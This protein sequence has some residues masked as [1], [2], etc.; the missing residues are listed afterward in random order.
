[1]SAPII[2]T[3]PNSYLAVDD[4]E[5]KVVIDVGPNPPSRKRRLDHLTWEE[6]MQRKKLK[7]RVAAQTSRDRKK[8]KMDEMESRI[9]ECMD[10]NERLVSE[11]ENLKA[12]NERLLSEN[13]TLRSETAART[14][15]GTPRPA[16]GGAP[17]GDPRGAPAAGDVPP[18]ADLLA[19]LDSEEY[20]DTLHQ[21][22]DSLLKEFDTSPAA[23]IEDIKV[24]DSRE[25]TQG[26]QV[27][28]SSTKQLE[29]S[30]SGILESLKHDVDRILAQH[31]Y[32]H[33]YPSTDEVQIKEEDGDKGDMF[34]ASYEANDCV[35]VEVPCDDQVVEEVPVFNVDTDFNT[36]TNNCSE[37][38][39]ECDMKLLS[40]MTLSPKSLE[41]NYLRVSPSHTSLSS[42]L[43]YES[44]SSP[45]SEHETMDLS[46]FWCE[47][48]SEL[49]PGLA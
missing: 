18:L 21:L 1:M 42:D 31:S 39:I 29:S 48:F 7:N 46:D 17:D 47:S 37:I 10:M 45:L 13:A 38:S 3:V 35:T 24:G 22:A 12:L 49:F 25:C 14:V 16:E 26:N 20:L 11:V 41:E 44:L 4:M 32:A 23:E 34:Y 15:A 43:G 19:H 28:G 9:K 36:L 33:P 2:I 27:V 5:S 6:K 40:P 8:A 30:Q